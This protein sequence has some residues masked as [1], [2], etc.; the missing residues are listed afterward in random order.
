MAP[1]PCTPLAPGGTLWTL[2]IWSGRCAAPTTPPTTRHRGSR[3]CCNPIPP[4]RA[5]PRLTPCPRSPRHLC[6]LLTAACALCMLQV[7]RRHERQEHLRL[8]LRQDHAVR[9]RSEKRPGR[10]SAM[11]KDHAV[12]LRSE[13]RPARPSA[14]TGPC[15]APDHMPCA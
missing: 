9:L 2:P 3:G 11:G 7:P 5:L 14:M 10:P 4:R 6:T 15:R 13:K 1:H 12:R 8:R